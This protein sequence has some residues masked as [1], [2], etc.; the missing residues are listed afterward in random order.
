MAYFD[1]K[2]AN[3]GNPPLIICRRY[4]YQFL[5]TARLSFNNHITA[6]VRIR[7]LPCDGGSGVDV[8]VDC[9]SAL[10]MAATT[11]SG[12]CGTVSSFYLFYFIIII[13][14]SSI[15]LCHPS[16]RTPTA[17]VPFCRCIP[18][19][20]VIV[21]PCPA[22][23]DK[24]VWGAVSSF[25]FVLLFLLF[26]SFSH[27]F[28][29]LTR[30]GSGLML[31]AGSAGIG[32]LQRRVYFSAWIDG[33]RH[34]ILHQQRHPSP[35]HCQ[36]RLIKRKVINTIVMLIV[37]ILPPALNKILFTVAT[38]LPLSLYLYHLSLSICCP[39]YKA[40][41]PTI[42]YFIVGHDRTSLSHHLSLYHPPL[43]HLLISLSLS[44]SLWHPPL[45]HH[46]SLLPFN[47]IEK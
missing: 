12:V 27:F 24:H 47:W 23:T 38:L 8:V 14:S 7:S 37:V 21:V 31:E 6:S 3:I 16:L 9:W 41:T 42:R 33:S 18:L 10:S 20:A 19:S 45:Q 40:P 29:P 25:C 2:T 11:D 26:G 17:S 32:G 35:L 44:L 15:L 30:V 36:P 34:I 28:V 1:R 13:L 5:L 22:T 43:Q 39:L 4:F 46:Q